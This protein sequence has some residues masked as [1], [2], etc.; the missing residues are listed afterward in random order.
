MTDVVVVG[1]G[2]AGATC[3]R[4]LRQAGV[5]V[6]LLDRGRRAGGRMASRRIDGRPVDLGASYLTVS[7]DA[8]RAQVEDWQRRGLVRPWTDTFAVAGGE[9][10]SGPMRWGTPGGLRS[11]VEDL[12]A[13]VPVSLET[14][15]SRVRRGERGWELDGEPA[16]TVV[17]A[18]PD[19]Q[20]RRLLD[21]GVASSLPPADPYEPVLALAARWAERT[22][23]FDGLFVNE[24]PV[25]AWVADDGRRRGDQAP[26]LVAHSTPAFAAQHLTDPAAAAPA[27]TRALTEVAELPEPSS[28]HLHRWS[29]AR[30]ARARSSSY[31]LT[32]DGLGLCGDSW[33][34]RPRVEAAYLS[35]RELALAL[36]DRG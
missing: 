29:F 22:W 31:V 3:A 24:H 17:L 34:D 20:A 5:E 1:A 18:M 32:E 35:G 8:F 21:P 19:P 7:D 9:P 11:L 36:L 6:R 26:V 16:S 4:T 15:V 28:T 25:L 14:T 10:T 23:D 33:S 13:D 27:L 12:V 2:L 30:P